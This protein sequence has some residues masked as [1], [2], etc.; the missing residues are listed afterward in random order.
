MNHAP[1]SRVM[2]KHYEQSNFNPPVMAIA[3]KEP[4]ARAQATMEAEASAALTRVV[5][6]SQ[7]N[8]IARQ[9]A[10]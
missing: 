7:V 6:Q 3:M 1:E 5:D 8:I 2:E 9:R 4:I 10:A